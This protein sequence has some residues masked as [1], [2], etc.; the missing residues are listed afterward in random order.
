MK[1][2]TA[3]TVLLFTLASATVQ[4]SPEEY[5]VDPSLSTVKS[6]INKNVCNIMGEYGGMVSDMIAQGYSNKSMSSE[7]IKLGMQHLDTANGWTATTMMADLVLLDASREW[8]RN[9]NYLLVQGK[10][11]ELTK[12]QMYSIYAATQ[13]ELKLGETVNTIR[14]VPRPKGKTS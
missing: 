14:I 3:F 10:H 4:A 7:I 5:M 11:P 6:D 13:C 8:D 2:K 1:L 9:A 12:K